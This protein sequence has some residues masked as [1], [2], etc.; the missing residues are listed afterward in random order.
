MISFPN[1]KST[2]GERERLMALLVALTE[3]A[4]AASL[5]VDDPMLVAV[6]R[7]H[8]LTPLLSTTCGAALPPALAS[9][10]RHDRLVTGARNLILCQAAEECIRALAAD[11]IPTIVLK[12]LDYE[13]R[14]YGAAATRPTA[15]VDLLVPGEKRR[16]AFNVLDRLGFAPRAAAPG[17]DESDYHEVAWTRAGVE[18]DLHLALAPLVR[19]RI[20]YA[21]V[22]AEA[23]P[24]RLGASETRA[25]ARPHAAVF[26]ALHMAIDHFDVPAIYVLDL[27]RLLRAP[28]DVSTAQSLAR[29]WHCR[30]PLETAL[31]LMASL[32]PATAPQGLSPSLL[33]QR[34]ID[35]YG[36][37][38]ALPRPEQ[39]LRKLLHFDAPGDAIRYV[40]VQSRRNLRELYERHIRGRSARDRLAS[41][42]RMG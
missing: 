36:A 23:E 25:L 27:Q 4:R 39:L 1:V 11:G 20:D 26:Q 6:A 41:A 16:T 12:G 19:C 7:H 29:R 24:F 17:F 5:P 22:W 21:A 3:P 9:A 15:D 32:L 30:R 2:A 28:A 31:A 37:T 33:A 10:F 38:T 34:V 13:T 18:I 8:R 35:S 42:G 40:A 14:L